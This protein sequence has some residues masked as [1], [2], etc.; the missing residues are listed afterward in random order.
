MSR[1]SLIAWVTFSSMFISAVM[2][3]IWLTTTSG[4][5][6][7]EP[8]VQALGLVFGLGGVLA[9]RR[10][11]AQERRHLMLL[12]LMD[13]L[14]RDITVLNDPQFAPSKETPRPRVY[15]RLPVSAT[16]A[17]LTSG[18]L[19]E[20]GDNELLRHLHHWR[21]KV[22]RFNRRL[23]LTEL[24]FFTLGIPEIGT[25]IVAFE[26]TLHRSGGYLDQIRCHARDLQNYLAAYQ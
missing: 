15:P 14:R 11:A 17:A 3:I 22:N 21:D 12:T 20:R 1:S 24:R 10:A 13:E 18:A 7:I 25:E 8:V 2:S 4:D 6:K 26:R 16:D 19:A 5:S 23:E 9:E